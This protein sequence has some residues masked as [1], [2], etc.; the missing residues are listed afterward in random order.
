MLQMM[1]NKV[2]EEGEREQELFEKFLCYCKNGGSE[3]SQSISD[4]EVKIPQLE[5]DIEAAGSAITQ[6]EDALK[7]HKRER[8]EAKAAI[9]EAVGVREKDAAAF[10][11][12]SSE[13]KAN[14]A[15]M[16]KA[17]PALEAGMAGSFLQSP[18]A[19]TLAR[20]AQATSALAGSDQQTL[21]EFLSQSQGDATSYAPASGEIV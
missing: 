6:L 14:I 21:L 4:A 16:E 20:A 11:K 13:S 18:A 9:S 5:S 2:K 12:E 15:A 19:Q 8:S 3:L 7:T 17:I 1:Q 10:A